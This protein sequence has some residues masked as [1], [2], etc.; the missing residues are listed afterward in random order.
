M[1]RLCACPCKRPLVGRAESAKYIDH[2]HAQRACRARLKASLRSAGLPSTLSLSLIEATT[3]TENHNGDG[4]RAVSVP[5]SKASGCQ[6]SYRKAVRAVACVI[7]EI[8][9]RLGSDEWLRRPGGNV[10]LAED[11]LR[12]ALPERQRKRLDARQQRQRTTA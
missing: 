10:R 11:A 8:E 3:S 2:S 1:I 6:V 9:E 12:P 7:C 5:R 4:K